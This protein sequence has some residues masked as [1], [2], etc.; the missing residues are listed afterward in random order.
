[1]K[2]LT[3]LAALALALM[4]VPN[5]S[6]ATTTA[7]FDFEN[8]ANDTS[9]NGND[10]SVVGTPQFLTSTPYPLVGNYCVGG[11]SDSNYITLPAT[12]L[13]DNATT[14][15]IKFSYFAPYNV[16]TQG[17][18]VPSGVMLGAN[19]SANGHLAVYYL[20]SYITF[21][22]PTVI[23]S[24][25][26][27]SS[28]FSIAGRWYTIYICYSPSALNIYAEDKSSGVLSLVATS[29]YS[30]DFSG[31][32]SIIIGHDATVGGYS[33]GGYVDNAEFK[34]TTTTA[35]DKTCNVEKHFATY[36]HSWVSDGG[37][38]YPNA[39]R[40]FAFDYWQAHSQN[41]YFYGQ[42]VAGSIICPYTDGV[43]G[44]HSWQIEQH[45]LDTLASN[46][47][48]P[49]GNDYVLLGPTE[50]NDATW[51]T[52]TACTE[53][54]IR[55]AIDAVSNYSNSITCYVVTGMLTAELAP[56]VLEPYISAVKTAASDAIAS[57]ENVKII[58]FGNN[59]VELGG[60]GLHP[61]AAGY[62]YIGNSIAAF[63]F[64]DINSTPVPTW[65][66]TSTATPTETETASPTETQ[67][68]TATPS[69]SPSPTCTMTPRITKTPYI[70]K[71]S[72]PTRTPARTS[73]PVKTGTP[74][75]YKTPTPTKTSTPAKTKTPYPVKTPT[76]TPTIGL[77]TLLSMSNGHPPSDWVVLDYA[78]GNG[79]FSFSNGVAYLGLTPTSINDKWGMYSSATFTATTGQ[80]TEQFTVVD[81]ITN[82]HTVW[83]FSL[84]DDN[85]GSAAFYVVYQYDGGWQIGF[86]G[87]AY[88]PLTITAGDNIKITVTYD[89]G[90]STG[91]WEFFLNGASIAT[92]PSNYF[93]GSVSF[94][95][96]DAFEL[97]FADVR[98]SNFSLTQGRPATT[99]TP[100][101]R[102]TATPYGYKTPTRTPT[103]KP[104]A[105]KTPYVYRTRTPTITPTP[106]ITQTSTRTATATATP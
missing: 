62:Q 50:I 104:K 67:T 2:K 96:I 85:N 16:P 79:I 59:Y 82:T 32:S 93:V 48:N 33:W 54:N 99:A 106:T 58:D 11:M 1:M 6:L 55:G 65:T 3:A 88:M 66:E 103:P 75:P 63:V 86:P 53:I 13:S 69:T 47:P 74:Y 25:P 94:S 77:T 87:M 92:G 29:A 39:Y 21:I 20:G 9:G 56:G 100:T 72:T 18:P 8:N 24:L 84:L 26:V 49:N 37:G 19:T 101:P 91:A 61:D 34:S 15:T 80:I 40:K 95:I 4:A 41:W 31:C 22:I 38:T 70:Y 52:P 5:F 51:N 76:P 83:G 81:S 14:G 10:G 45:V 46:F 23:G 35:E 36:G 17:Y 73:T 102:K 30:V 97:G 98:I 44:S 28:N 12:I 43:G 90:T 7:F 42:T 27:N 68:C 78:T 64:N 71:T 89:P 57:G 105:T 60:D